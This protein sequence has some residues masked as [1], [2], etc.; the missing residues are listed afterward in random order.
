MEAREVV[1][2]YYAALESGDDAA[3]DAL[4][5][6]G[7]VRHM[8]G[9]PPGRAVVRQHLEAFRAGFPDLRFRVE[10][11][12]AEGDLV[13][14]RTTTEGTHTGPFM[15]HPP[16]GRRF[17]AGGIDIFRVEEGRL[18]EHWGQFD[19]LAMLQQLGLYRPVPPGES[20]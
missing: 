8:P 13:S 19:T 9:V 17:R 2:R 10:A 6:E 5:D 18:Q 16:T 20:R 11:L 3:L 4:V 7:Y 12:I 1:R 15:G 14:A